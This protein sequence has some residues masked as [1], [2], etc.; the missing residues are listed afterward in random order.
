LFRFLKA[1]KFTILAIVVV[2]LI[3]AFTH[4]GMLSLK[5]FALTLGDI[6][7]GELYEEKEEVQWYDDYFTI[8][9]IDAHTIAIGEPR[10]WQ[11]NYNYLILGNTRAILF[12][13]GPGVRDLSGLVKSL[14][15]LPVTV[16]SSHLHFD[17]VG[18]H[19][20]FENVALIDLPHL[21]ELEAYGLLPLSDEQHLGFL[22]STPTPVLEI[23][24][25]WPV[26]EWQDIG[27]RQLKVL[28]APGHTRDSMIL[29]D[30]ERGQLFTGDF[31]YPGPL[32]AYLPGS[33]VEEYLNTT[34]ELLKLINSETILLTA[35]RSKAPGAPLLRSRDLEDLLLTLEEI[36]SGTRKGKGVFPVT[37]KVNDEIDLSTDIFW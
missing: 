18:N 23:D 26:N 12:D 27:G 13:S 21:R 4:R 8:E 17:H 9:Y 33:D 7:L 29:Y 1:G 16:V 28:H 2:A 20:K 22:E 37:Y 19:D 25:W 30:A 31:I 36:Q 34:I 14:T 10:Y 35:H 11:A 15:D 32:F 6:E 24:E 5:L 3:Y